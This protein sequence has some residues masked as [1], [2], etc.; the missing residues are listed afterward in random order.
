MKKH[1]VLGALAVLALAACTKSEVV[2]LNRG[3]EISL[4]ATTG[5][6]L[7]KAADGYCNSVKP[8]S[9][10]VWASTTT[11]K[12]VYFTNETYTDHNYSDPANSGTYTSTTAH[13]W[14]AE[15]LDFFAAMNYNGTVNFN[16]SE[17]EPF[18][19][20]GYTVNSSVA[21]QTDF[22][23]A[24]NKNQAKTGTGKAPLN[25]R[26]ALSQIEFKA[27]NSNANIR[28]FIDGVKVGNVKSKGD[29][30][31]SGETDGTF[32]DHT[33]TFD[34]AHPD[35]DSRNAAS[36]GT[37][38]NQDVNKSYSVTFAEKEVAS[39]T[40]VNLTYTTG[41][42]NVNSMYLLPQTLDVWTGGVGAESD[43]QDKAYFVVN[44]LIYNVADPSASFNKADNVVLWG[45]EEAGSWKTKPIAVKI[46]SGLTWEDG[47]RY[48]YTFNFTSYGTGGSDPSSGDP[49]LTPIELTVTVDD[50]VDA[51]NT[52]VN[53]E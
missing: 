20:T 53:V 21:A 22:I 5:K 19:F 7:T 35:T 14:P 41:E 28:V 8:E 13:Y 32:V 11:G 4:S 17:A 6:N 43:G 9:F 30:K 40:T 24:V 15:N 46:P 44:A 2:E 36:R 33:H 50:F 18:T 51:G 34:P 16:P 25:F 49:V 23:Y 12:K 1:L 39:G 37:W 26:H 52:N 31:V 10:T 38:S 45:K 48:V 47:K 42:H 27:T 29:F 3:N